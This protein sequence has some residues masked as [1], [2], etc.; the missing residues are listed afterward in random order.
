MKSIFA[1]YGPTYTRRAYRMSESAFYKLLNLL[2]P[3]LVKARR[4]T[5]G[6]GTPNGEIPLDLKLSIALRYFAGGDVYDIMIS[7]GV[8]HSAVYACIWAVVDAVNGTKQ[9]KISFPTDHQEQKEMARR[10]AV[11]SQASFDCCV[12]AI[13]GMLVWVTR[14]TRTECDRIKVGAARFFCGRKKKYGVALQA[15]CDAER[16]FT[17]VYIGLPASA[18]DHL[19]FSQ[20]PLK[21]KL[22]RDGILA[23]GLALFGDAAYMNNKYMVAPFRNASFRTQKDDFNYYQS[24]VRINI[25]CAFGMLTQRWGVLRKPIQSCVGIG[26]S[27]P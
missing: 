12:G 6:G 23:P 11:K 7:H 2:Q 9:L 16:R 18:S 26:K 21:T 3:R 5:L 13:D 1:E 15:V 19:V 14:P 24:Q 10:F 20:S 8:S 17:D 4:K 22:E 25:E 27:L